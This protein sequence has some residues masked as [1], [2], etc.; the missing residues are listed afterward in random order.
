MSADMTIPGLL[1]GAS[2]PVQ[3]VMLLLI[4]ASLVSW[5]IIFHQAATDQAHQSGI[6]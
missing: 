4:V 1:L 5:S 2:I 6:R 3:I